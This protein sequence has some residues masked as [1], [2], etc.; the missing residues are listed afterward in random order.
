MLDPLKKVLY[1][2]VDRLVAEGTL[3]ED[4]ARKIREA[5]LS[6]QEKEKEKEKEK[7]KDK[8]REKDDFAERIE[9]ELRRLV[10]LL[11]VVSRSEF[12]TLEERVSRLEARVP[13][14]TNPTDPAP[15]SEEVAPS[16]GDG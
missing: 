6:R 10:E 15:G 7:D 9:R 5:L 3:S 14:S 12:R 8:E 4:D 2:V 16:P 1:F 13:V 11:P